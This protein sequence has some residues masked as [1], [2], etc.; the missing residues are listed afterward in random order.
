MEEKHSQRGAFK[1][2]SWL[3]C[4]G[5]DG[6]S[7]ELGRPGCWWLRWPGETRW[8]QLVPGGGGLGTAQDRVQKKGEEI[9]FSAPPP[10]PSNLWKTTV[11]C[12]VVVR[13]NT[14]RSFSYLFCLKK[15]FFFLDVDLFKVFIELLQCCFCLIF[16]FPGHKA[17][18][19]LLPNQRANP[20][21][22]PWKKS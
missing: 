10:S 4:G 20:Q 16:W 21:P 11:L 14:S 12:W 2:F 6:A 19:I 17:C 8:C 5:W 15:K 22:L 9:L 13:A 18:G 3:E 1:R 7:V